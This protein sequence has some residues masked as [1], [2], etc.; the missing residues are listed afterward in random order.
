MKRHTR[1]LFREVFS[2]LGVL[3]LSLLV[4]LGSIALVSA[5]WTDEVSISGSITTGTWET[6][7]G[8]SPGFWM[9]WDK[10]KT[11]TG[12]EIEGFLAA[13]DGNSAWQGPT[14]T[15]GMEA[16]LQ[17]AF[18]PGATPERRFL[19]H[20]LC[21]RLN[22][23]SGRLAPWGTHNVSPC[24]PENYLNLPCPWSATVDDIINA[25]EAKRGTPVSTDQF[26]IMQDVCES[27]HHS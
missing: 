21:T 2:R 23:E 15:A 5:A 27:T 6:D 11:Y 24:D 13:I 19:A 22:V 1:R 8:G 12:A 3:C 10:H 7:Q 26:N 9:N 17:A 18:G 4:A 14:S 25:I 16:V 20:Y